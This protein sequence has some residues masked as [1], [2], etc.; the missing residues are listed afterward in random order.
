MSAKKKIQD[1]SRLW[2]PW[3]VNQSAMLRLLQMTFEKFEETPKIRPQLWKNRFILHHDSA[4][5]ATGIS[6]EVFGRKTNSNP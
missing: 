1:F 2:Q 6:Q 3:T 5:C 4:H